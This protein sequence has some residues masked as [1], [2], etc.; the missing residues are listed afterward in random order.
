MAGTDRRDWSRPLGRETPGCRGQAHRES[1]F[2]RA[3][4][5]SKLQKSTVAQQARKA[6]CH[7]VSRGHISDLVD[8]WRREEVERV[9]GKHGLRECDNA[10]YSK[11][12]SHF[13][14]LAG[15]SGAALN[16]LVRDQSNGAR[17]LRYVI[18]RTLVDAGL[19]AQYAE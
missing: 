12:L 15:D 8:T 7:Q 3:M 18:N 1:V 14:D 11:L 13:A 17:Q 10:D 9:T 5:L 2:I 19:H 16:H 4:S 6:Y